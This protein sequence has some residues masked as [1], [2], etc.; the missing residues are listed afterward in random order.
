MID[1]RLQVIPQFAHSLFLTRTLRKGFSPFVW[2]FSKTFRPS[3]QRWSLGLLVLTVLLLSGCTTN[4]ASSTAL[5]TLAPSSPFY[6]AAFNLARDSG[7][8]YIGSI[9]SKTSG[10]LL[11]DLKMTNTGTI[12]GTLNQGLFTIQYLHVDKKDFFQAPQLFWLAHGLKAQLADLYSKQWVEITSSRFGIDFAQNL[13]PALL[14]SQLKQA[15]GAISKN[16]GNTTVFKG[17]PVRQINT[18]RMIVYITTAQPYRVVGIRSLKTAFPFPQADILSGKHLA[19]ALFDVEG[20][21]YEQAAVVDPSDFELVANALSDDEQEQLLNVLRSNVEQLRNT[22]DE[23]VQLTV[24]GS[25]TLSPCTQTSCTAQI[26]ITNT[27]TTDSPYIQ[28]PPLVKVELELQ[29]TVDG[30]LVQTCS[31]DI[32]MPPNS[33][34]PAKS[35]TATYVLPRDGRQ[36]SIVAKGVG[37]G[38]ATAS[39][40]I[41]KMRNDLLQQTLSWRLKQAGLTGLPGWSSSDGPYNF[42]PPKDYNPERG[43]LRKQN[44]GYIDAYGNLWKEGGAEGLAAAEGFPKEWDVITN[45][46]SSKSNNPF[47]SITRIPK[48]G[49]PHANVTPDGRLSH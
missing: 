37:I 42:I 19:G 1:I 24:T 5:P 12:R 45:L 31:D 28:L 41:I 4:Q 36:H 35:C 46:N 38:E 34:V 40:D 43:A 13:A 48:K 39:I 47:W 29:M 49:D 10:P 2:I 8:R 9:T 44:G 14:G 30:L 22:L 20:R 7:E 3:F 18:P 23:R 17:L 32:E 21:G 11:V 25:T 16:A 33:T 27:V 15:A 6:R 26:K